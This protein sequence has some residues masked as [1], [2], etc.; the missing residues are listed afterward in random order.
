MAFV[1]R[2]TTKTMQI[3]LP[4]R[5]TFIGVEQGIA[6]FGEWL[7]LRGYIDRFKLFEALNVSYTHDCRIG[8]ALVSQEILGRGL[9]EQEV[10]VFKN[11]QSL[12]AAA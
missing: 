6:G 8:D 2:D 11:Y 1:S 7:V 12:P 4:W 9:I 10:C 3:K 5:A